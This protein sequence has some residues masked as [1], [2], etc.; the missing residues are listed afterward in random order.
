MEKRSL[1]DDSPWGQGMIEWL[2]HVE[3][4]CVEN[5]G[6]TDDFMMSPYFLCL[7]TGGNLIFKVY[8]QYMMERV[9]RE[10]NPTTLFVGI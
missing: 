10:G 2:A 7:I 8:K 5:N 6:R 1:V 9:W 4:I 3:L